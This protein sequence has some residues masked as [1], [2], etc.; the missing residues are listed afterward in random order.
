MSFSLTPTHENAV[1]SRFCW[2]VPTRMPKRTIMGSSAHPTNDLNE[3]FTDNIIM[4]N[5][6]TSIVSRPWNDLPM[7]L[8]ES[9]L[10]HLSS[11]D[12]LRFFTVCKSWNLAS[13]SIQKAKTWPW[14][15]YQE[16]SDGT[17]KLLDPLNGKEYTTSVGLPS[18]VF[19]IRM[20]CSKDG[21]VIVLDAAK[22][23]FMVNPLNED[24]VELPPLEGFDENFCGI[25][26]TSTPTSPDCVVL[27]FCA[28]INGDIFFYKWHSE[29]EDWT[30]ICDDE[31]P[32]MHTASKTN[33]VFFQGEFYCL[34]E[35][36]E[37]GIFNPVDKTWRMLHKLRPVYLEDEVPSPGI[38]DCYLL[39]LDGNLI[40]VFKCNYSNNDV[41]IIKLDTEKMEWI[42]VK[43]LA[44]WTLFL[45]PTG[46]FAKPSPHK[47]WSNKI[48]FTAFCSSKIKTCATYC[49]ESKRYDI[50][51]CD[52][53]KP[54]DCVW[55]EPKLIRKRLMNAPC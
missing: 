44:G 25:T 50:H 49:M 43:D 23:M 13:D 30:F 27:A 37:L 1:G 14:L 40:S 6:I 2:F 21:W 52:T 41:R 18:S 28:D 29:D 16:K 35:T 17:C 36:G 31:S 46:S 48:F 53:K 33:P 3:V 19:P 9:L 45:D 4:E 24:A 51:F 5:K 38:E 22:A 47:N 42:P 26:F 11:V 12:A 32:P 20:L 10:P 54:L 34:A 39:E 7:D 55:L 8:V 15:M